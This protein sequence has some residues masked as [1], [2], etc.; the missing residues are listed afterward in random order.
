MA[1]NPAPNSWTVS[2]LKKHLEEGPTE[3]VGDAW[4]PMR[5]PGQDTFANRFA[6]AVAVFIGRADA[7]FWTDR[8]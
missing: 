5:M 2:S 6:L 8:Q 4:V 1:D 3:K 7:L